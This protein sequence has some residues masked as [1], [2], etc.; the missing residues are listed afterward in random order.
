MGF[1]MEASAEWNIS[2][3]PP[4]PLP[5]ISEFLFGTGRGHKSV[6][7]SATRLQEILNPI[8]YKPGS[9][10]QPC[11]CS[12]GYLFFQQ[13]CYVGELFLGHSGPLWGRG[14]RAPP[15]VSGTVYIET[16]TTCD[17]QG[18][19]VHSPYPPGSAHEYAPP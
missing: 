17:F 13:S 16:H 5:Q 10:S 2:A 15:L 4:P 3:P 8:I 1:A 6:L 19:R 18:V 9:H 14:G 7:S 12:Q 11:L